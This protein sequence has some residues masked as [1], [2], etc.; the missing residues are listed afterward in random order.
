MN[1]VDL[2]CNQRGELGPGQRSGLE[3][4][5]TEGY[6]PAHTD[7]ISRD[8]AEGR[9]MTFDGEIVFDLDGV[10][11]A[12][13]G[14]DDDAL[15]HSSLVVYMG[16]YRAVVAGH[17]IGWHLPGVNLLPG[18]YRFYM[19]PHSC[20]IVGAEAPP[21]AVARRD[22]QQRMSAI[23][24][25]V[26]KLDDAT[27]TANREGR[28]TLAQQRAIRTAS[29]GKGL[30]AFL[31]FFFIS[32]GYA[33]VEFVSAHVGGYSPEFLAYIGLLLSIF[34]AL[35]IPYVYRSDLADIRKRRDDVLECRV[36]SRVGRIS[37][38]PWRTRLGGLTVEILMGEDTFDLQDRPALFAAVVPGHE[39]RAY[40]T[41][42]GR[43]LLFLELAE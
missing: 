43:K 4:A 31:V 3:Q 26:Q 24:R 35:F 16:A 37:K 40:L 23:L 14:G 6:L 11:K 27:L 28:L 18:P 33:L 32:A 12:A 15:E 5:R 21:P 19:A 39:Y 25:A 42:H 10:E 34:C 30:E 2:R 8:L 9:V 20:F 7:A 17:P 41:P 22:H 36:I 38:S 1:E 29:T 13:A